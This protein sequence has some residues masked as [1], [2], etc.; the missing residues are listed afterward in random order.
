IEIYN[1]PTD[2]PPLK[3]SVIVACG[4]DKKSTSIKV[5]T[6]NINKGDCASPSPL[7]VLLGT[8]CTSSGFRFGDIFR[9]RG[10]DDRDKTLNNI[11]VYSVADKKINLVVHDDKTNFSAPSWSSDGKNIAFVAH[12]D[13]KGQI[14]LARLDGN[15][16]QFLTPGPDDSDP[17]W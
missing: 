2:N 11:S 6:Q 10:L 5:P 1:V 4:T 12:K 8:Y 13:G 3:Y 14:A 7:S 15:N 17:I 16:Y 9:Q